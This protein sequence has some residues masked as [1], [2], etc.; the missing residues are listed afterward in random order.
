MGRGRSIVV[1]GAGVFG[2]AL[3]RRCAMTGWDVTL[4]E[5]VAPGHVRAGSGGESRLI[6]AAHGDDAWHAQ[7]S[8]RALVLWHE[9]DPNLVV[10]AGVAW[11]AR[12][13]DGWEAA[14][15]R[16]LRDLGIP[17]ERVDPAGL[18]PSF[19]GD[20]I[21]FALLEPDAGVLRARDATR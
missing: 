18:F 16:T 1:V 11:L 6:R 4:V 13:E 15:E 17:C 7:L 21:A 5:R 10:E 2:A 14:S 3:A 9:L 12:R 19:A 8:R 20:E